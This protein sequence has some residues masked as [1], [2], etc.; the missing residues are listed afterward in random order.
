MAEQSLR[1]NYA[2]VVGGAGPAGMG[3]LFNA[4]KTGALASL[5]RD[6]LLVV[7][8]ALAV[9]RGRLGDYHI[10]ANS[11]GD[12]FLDC[13]RDPAL[14]PIFAP[15]AHSPAFRALQ[16]DPHGAPMLTQVGELLAH[17]S[18]LFMRYVTEHLASK[19]RWVPASRRSPRRTTAASSWRCAVA[20]IACRS[21]PAH[22]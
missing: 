7:D 6:G 12:V 15:L 4:Y 16:N 10:T 3:F 14:L 20:P 21:A 18:T 22:W 5:A 1:S 2:C 13:L 11:V 17:A 19:W 8:A 9:G